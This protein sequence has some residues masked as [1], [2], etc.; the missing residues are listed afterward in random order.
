LSKLIYFFISLHQK[1][2]KKN[3]YVFC[4]YFHNL[5]V[6]FVLY[7]THILLSLIKFVSF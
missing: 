6:W 7:T 1:P 4:I 5:L 2:K 3:Y